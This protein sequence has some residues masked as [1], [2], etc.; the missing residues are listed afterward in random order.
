MGEGV[1]NTEIPDSHAFSGVQDTGDSC[2]FVLSNVEKP[3]RGSE[4]GAR[5]QLAKSYFWGK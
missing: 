1:R 5:N 3:L 4:A 2:P